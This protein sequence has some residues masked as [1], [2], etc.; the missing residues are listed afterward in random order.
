VNG[1]PEGVGRTALGAA[2]DTFQAAANIDLSRDIMAR[3]PERLLALPLSGV[4]WRDWGN[5][6][7]IDAVI[8]ARS[9]PTLRPVTHV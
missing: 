5:G 1:V 9:N 6:T 7:R 4:E 2:R 8:A 3:A